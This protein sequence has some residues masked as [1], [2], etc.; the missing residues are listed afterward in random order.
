LADVE[1]VSA[2]CQDPEISRWTAMIPWPYREEHARE[3]IAGHGLLWETGVAAEF[4]ITAADH[5][6]LLG[7]NGLRFDWPSNTAV[8]GYWVAAWAR[9]RGVATRA[10]RL[11]TTWAL[12]TFGL[13]A[14]ELVTMVGN[15][16]SERVS[17][18]AGFEMVGELQ[19]YEHPIG[20]EHRYHVRR[21]LLR[22]GNG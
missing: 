10:L 19:D 2:A 20:P 6:E 1:E 18:K 21:W 7:S 22:S 15:V 16:A 12:E 5:G 13:V 8:A 14:V 17:E 11:S 4:A 3:W 9:N